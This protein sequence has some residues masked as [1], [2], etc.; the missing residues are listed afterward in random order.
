MPD[1]FIVEMWADWMA[2]SYQYKG[3]WDLTEW[4]NDVLGDKGRFTKMFNNKQFE[5]IYTI[6]QTCGYWIDVYNN[7]YGWGELF[8][9]N[10][11]VLIPEFNNV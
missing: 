7:N 11:D 8:G 2:A 1:N 10:K 3:T 9:A 5:T 6:A 4:L